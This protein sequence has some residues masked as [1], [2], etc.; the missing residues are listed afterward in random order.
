MK[1]QVYHFKNAPPIPA[2]V[3]IVPWGFCVYVATEL[4]AYKVGYTHRSCEGGYSVEPVLDEWRV[5]V[6]RKNQYD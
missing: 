1:R 2:S 4:E 3:D 5:T 6:F